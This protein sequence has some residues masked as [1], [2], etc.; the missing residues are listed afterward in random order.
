MFHTIL[1]EG[2]LLQL[3][4]WLLVEQI[5]EC[6]AVLKLK[7]PRKH[8]RHFLCHNKSFSEKELEQF[9]SRFKLPYQQRFWLACKLMQC[10][11]LR[12]CE[13]AT[14][15]LNNFDFERQVL[16]VVNSK[17]EGRI[18]ELPLKPEIIYCL[19]QYVSTYKN[20]IQASAGYFFFS[21][22]SQ[23][24]STAY[25]RNKFSRQ[26]ER[27]G[28]RKELSLYSFRHWFVNAIYKK[29]G[30]NAKLTQ[31]A[32]RHS[33]FSTTAEYYLEADNQEVKNVILAV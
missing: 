29:S 21:K 27:A 9:F 33:D 19:K 20:R 14:L 7:Y 12:P 18:D 17:V 23:Y 2:Y 1:S 3:P 26:R 11:G 8:S 22:K 10:L 25:L 4:K 16:R 24:W 28:L 15:K 30:F 6:N 5:K 13:L 32:A 31:I